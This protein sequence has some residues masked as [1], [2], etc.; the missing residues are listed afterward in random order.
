MDATATWN[1]EGADAD[2]FT[3]TGGMLKFGS[4]PDFESPMGGADNDS[5]TYMVT[6]MAS[7]GGEEEM[8][9]V[10]ITVDNVDELG[11]LGG[12]DTA[13]IN[14]GATDVGSYTVSGG[15]M[16]ATAT[17]NVE[18]ADADHFTITG[19][20]LKFGSA[21]DFESPMGGADND[22]NTYMVTVMASAGG[23]E[24]MMAV[25]IT[26]DNVDE[27]GA[28]GGSDTASINEGATD[29]GSY[30]VS[31]GTMDATATWNVEGADADHFTIT[32]GMLKF[33]SA[34]DFEKPNGRRRQ[35]LQRPTWSPS[36][37]RPA[38]KWPG[39][40]STSWSPTWSNLGC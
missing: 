32:G 6:V 35:R 33:G 36:R 30:T 16:D 9:A 31:G 8:M 4:A 23:E 26:V 34:P 39:R 22:S 5:N 17:W 12:S 20:M 38:A 15:T 11:A 29:V 3:I 1:V 24:E 14:E 37:P 28:L 18:G 27:L 10:A 19:G 2:H 25:A 7:A 13:S 21:P 40:Q